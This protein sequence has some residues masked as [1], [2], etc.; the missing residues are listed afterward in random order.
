MALWTFNIHEAARN[1]QL[2]E[3]QKHVEAHPDIDVDVRDR[4]SWTPLHIACEAGFADI[5]DYLLT[6]GA[7][8]NSR[9]GMS[10]WTPL[11]LAAFR[12]R[13]DVVEVLIDSG[14]A[15][16]V[17][18]FFHRT[19]L[20][21]AAFN[22]A[23]KTVRILL[24]NGADPTAV[25]LEGRRPEDTL[26]DALIL[27]EQRDEIRAMLRA[28]QPRRLIGSS[29]QPAAVWVPPAAPAM[30]APPL[31]AAAPSLIPPILKRRPVSLD[32]ET[33]SAIAGSRHGR[34]SS[35][36]SPVRSSTSGSPS[37]DSGVSGGAAAEV[38]SKKYCRDCGNAINTA[39]KYCPECGMQQL[40]AVRFAAVAAPKG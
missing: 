4:N 26:E 10:S 22:G 5:A 32:T 20:H 35:A 24:D 37:S 19:P 3:I 36:P 21:C 27:D 39:Y 2:D 13:F 7:Q 23:V 34:R 40:H 16:D 9:G 12:N 15:C 33:R 18:G 8:V 38:S 6:H 29:P 1:G 14:A 17:R 11:H 30:Q 28:A 25:D 31:S